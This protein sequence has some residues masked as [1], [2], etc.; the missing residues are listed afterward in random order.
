MGLY[1]CATISLIVF[2]TAIRGKKFA[3]ILTMSIIT[4][5]LILPGT[6]L[7]GMSA[8][9]YPPDDFSEWSARNTWLIASGL[10]IFIIAMIL[11]IIR[12]S[13]KSR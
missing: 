6:C 1:V 7:V 5:V 2:M 12:H 3:L 8:A 10:V 13:N 9:N 11:M 4:L